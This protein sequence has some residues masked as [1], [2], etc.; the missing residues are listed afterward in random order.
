[1][2]KLILEDELLEEIKQVAIVQKVPPA[3]I[4]DEAVSVYLRQLELKKI[5]EEAEAF[6]SMHSEL[7]R[8]YKGEYVAI[9]NA[10]VVDHDKEFQAL[11]SRIRKRFGRQAVLLRPVKAE[12][13]REWSFRSPRS[14]SRITHYSLLI[15]EYSCSKKS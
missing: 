2:D 5:E 7:L 12:R 9:H 1:M 6:R 10:K 3:R 8:K 15:T 4:L 13:E 14:E 11:H